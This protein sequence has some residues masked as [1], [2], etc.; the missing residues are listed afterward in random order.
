M[1]ELNKESVLAELSYEDPRAALAWLTEAFGC[2]TR[3]IVADA[4]GR[5]IFAETGWSECTVGVVPEQAGRLHSPKVTGGVNT[6]TVQIRFYADIE[7][8]FARAKAAGAVMLSEPEQTFYGDRFYLAA[9]LEGHI[10]SFS[11]RVPGSGG[12]PPEGWTVQFP[13]RDHGSH[14]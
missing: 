1:A 9:D 8:H 12:P 2:E 4:D 6:Q 11:Q 13:S 7:A 14:A 5:L 10:W 3:M